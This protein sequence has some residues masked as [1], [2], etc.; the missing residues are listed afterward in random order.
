MLKLNYIIIG[1]LPEE[2]KTILFQ[3]L[4]CDKVEIEQIGERDKGTE[5]DKTPGTDAG[6]EADKIAETCRVIVPGEDAAMRLADYP[7]E[8]SL[9]ISGDAEE[10]HEAH[11]LGMAALG[12]LQPEGEEAADGLSGSAL[13]GNQQGEEQMCSASEGNQQGEELMRSA[14]KENLQEGELVRS[15]P[16]D[17]YAEGFEEIGRTFLLH[18]YERHH[19]IPW[20]ILTTKRCVVKEFSMEYLDELFELY[21]GEGMTDYIEPLYPYEEERAYQEAYIEHMYR[22]YGYGM[23]IVCDKETGALIGRAGIE[24]REEL[25]GELEL[26]YAIGAPWQHQGYATEV[27]TAILAYAREELDIPSVCCLIE[28]GNAVSEHL[29][30][31]LGLGWRGTLTIDGKEMRRY[32]RYF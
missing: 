9:L 32:I 1:K 24:H 23:W 17:M 4:A 15:A 13:K 19:G 7:A 26:G 21:A 11:G 10:L 29:A 3:N 31:K 22:F 8:E 16:A 25:G 20:T 28:E 2:Q 18:V 30:K 27:C 6:R 5:P 12:Y 14:L